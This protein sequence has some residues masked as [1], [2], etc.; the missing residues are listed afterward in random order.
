MT[1]LGNLYIKALESGKKVKS[2]KSTEEKKI[3]KDEEGEYDLT[4]E[5]VEREPF[6]IGAALAEF[7]L[8]FKSPHAKMSYLA[9]FVFCCSGFCYKIWLWF[10]A[11]VLHWYDAPCKDNYTLFTMPFIYDT[12]LVS[13]EE[14]ISPFFF[15]FTDAAHIMLSIHFS[16]YVLVY[17]ALIRFVTL[18][19]LSW[20]GGKC[21]TC[22]RNYTLS[23]RRRSLIR[24]KRMS[25]TQDQST[26][27]KQ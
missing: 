15:S 2:L 27:K 6:R 21:K 18:P 19:F 1:S 24:R 10:T 22:F 16:L 7:L 9:I 11:C 25:V 20:C 23:V 13:N 3:T 5:E 4:D 8:F 12:S 14:F 26:K 17:Y